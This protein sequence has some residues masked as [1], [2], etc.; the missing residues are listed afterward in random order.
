M[1]NYYALESRNIRPA[2]AIAA[3]FVLCPV[4]DRVVLVERTR[5]FL[6]RAFTPLGGAGCALRINNGCAKWQERVAQ[7]TGGGGSA[8]G[9]ED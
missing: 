1:K 4:L 3:A 9:V 5:E 2:S 8:R 6:G 7:S